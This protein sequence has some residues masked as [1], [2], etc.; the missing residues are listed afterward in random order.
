LLKDVKQDRMFSRS[1]M[2]LNLQKS[3]TGNFRIQSQYI[4]LT[5]GG[6]RDIRNE[7]L[8]ANVLTPTS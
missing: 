1:L 3:K 8:F 6:T 7:V 4:C 2:L 5:S